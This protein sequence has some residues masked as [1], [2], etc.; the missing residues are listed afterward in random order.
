[1]SIPFVSRP[2]D[3]TPRG[4]GSSAWQ[5]CET[6]TEVASSA[7]RNM[8]MQGQKRTSARRDTDDT[9]LAVLT[10]RKRGDARLSKAGWPLTPMTQRHSPPP[11]LQ[12]TGRCAAV[13]QK[14][15]YL[16]ASVHY[17]AGH[18][19]GKCHGHTHTRLCAVPVAIQ[20]QYILLAS[21]ILASPLLPGPDEEIWPMSLVPAYTLHQKG[22]A[23]AVPLI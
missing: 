5:R 15:Y 8:E 23:P 12:R 9:R 14:P 18:G 10:L 2:C 16:D 17:A 7:G 3:V 13:A 20:P 19:S 1:M 22:I 11:M 21:F 4:G 6:W